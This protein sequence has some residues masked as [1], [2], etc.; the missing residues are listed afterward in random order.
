MR[1]R[2][3]VASASPQVLVTAF[4]AARREETGILDFANGPQTRNTSASH[5]RNVR[6][7]EMFWDQQG[8]VAR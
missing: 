4:W 7:R 8:L 5:Y 1:G 3:Q 2:H 6:N